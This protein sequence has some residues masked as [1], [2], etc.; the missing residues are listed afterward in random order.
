MRRTATTRPTSRSGSRAC[1]AA[2][3][4]RS[5]RRSRRLRRGSRR[6]ARRRRRSRLRQPL[7]PRRMV[8]LLLS[9]RCSIP[10]TPTEAADG[11]RPGRDG[12]PQTRPA[13]SP[14]PLRATARTATRSR[15]SSRATGDEVEREY[16]Y[17]DAGAQMDKFRASVDAVRRG[18]EPPRG[19]LPRRLSPRSPGRSDP[20]AAMRE[21]IEASLSGF[22]STSTRGAARARSRSTCRRRSRWMRDIYEQDGAVWAPTTRVRRRQG[23]RRRPRVRR[24]VHVFRR[25]HRVRARQARA[26]FRHGDVCPRR[27]PPRLRPAAACGGRGCSGTTPLAWRWRCISSSTSRAAARP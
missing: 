27:R 16:Y 5:P 26:R 12:P 8:R 17:N 23:P 9:R 20:V 25:R 6:R 15:G 19:R 18:E 1:V 22:A 4:A 24:D 7:P 11:A 10:V 14:C 21:S 2:H 3:R 13:R